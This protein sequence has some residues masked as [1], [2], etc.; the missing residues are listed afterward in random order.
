MIRPVRPD[1]TIE[2]GGVFVPIPRRRVTERIASAAMQ[3]VVLI[4]AP[5]GYGKSVALGQYLEGVSEPCVR[6]D[7]LPDCTAL[8]GFLRGFADAIAHVAPDARAT[9]PGAYEKNASSANAGADLAL[10]M[11]SHLKEFRGTI[12]IDDLHVAQDDREVTRFLASLIERT[13]GGVQ[14][15]IA[16]RSTQ[17][18]PIGTWLAYS[19]SDLAID[20]HDLKFSVEEAKDAARS[21]RLGVRDDELNELLKLTD[22]WA[23]AMTFALRSSTR[24]VDLRSISTMTREMIYRYL[25]EQVYG[26]LSEDERAFLETAALLPEIDLGVMV[27]SGFD[28]AAALLEE[29]RARVAFIQEQAS[30][31]YRLHDLFREFVLHERALLG[32]VDARSRALNVGAALESMGRVVPALR[33]YVENRDAASIARLL[34]EHGVEL[35][36]K[37]FVDDVEAAI[38]S[39]L[40]VAFERDATVVGLRGLL[41]LHRG[42]YAQGERLLNKALRLPGPSALKGELLLRIAI[43]QFNQGNDPAESLRQGVSDNG[44]AASQQL[45]MEAFLAVCHARFA[46]DDEA[47]SVAER[48]ASRLADVDGGDAQARIL[49]RLG[50]VQYFLKRGASAKALLSQAVEMAVERALWGVASRAHLNLSLTVFF[51]EGDPTLSLWHA[52]QAAAAATKAGDFRDLQASLLAILSFETRRGNAEQAIQIEK[53]LAELQLNETQRISFIVSSQAHRHAWARRFGEAHRLFGSVLDRQQHQADRALV[54]AMHSFCSAMD[55]QGKASAASVEKALEIVEVERATGSASGAIQ[56][57][58]AMLMVVVAEAVA[59]RMTS[60]QRTLKRIK[61]SDELVTRSM[62][63]IVEQI[64]RAARAP[65]YALGDVEADLEV[66]RGRGYGGYAIHLLNAI[67]RIT[68]RPESGV[69]VVLTASELRIIQGLASGLTPKDIAVEMGRSVLTVQTHI[70]N[71]IDKLGC[72]GRAEALAAARQLGLLRDPL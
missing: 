34:E 7:V 1:G 61:A 2:T 20:E 11:Y 51:G 3:R 8:L 36:G 66:M 22:G 15:I 50:T 30:G 5:A 55:G 63:A 42:R 29:L 6:F 27:A 59:G 48:V 10:W 53:Q 47:L 12:A 67:K 23:T 65:S 58:M 52:Q 56:C 38:G 68:E 71:I 25:A 17:G 32:D 24:S 28:R 16:S 57:E 49:L 31:A 69:E 39:E 43:H 62:Y 4:V 18:L 41:E 33:L 70:K 19:E 14:W 26:T 37:G 45:E 60:A 64:L 44:L 9:L 35:I 46:R 21:F 54:Y 72:H 13:R 40:G